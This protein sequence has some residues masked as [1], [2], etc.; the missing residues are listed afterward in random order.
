M[1]IV[2]ALIISPII[3]AI[4]TFL[5]IV[6]W[7]LWQDRLRL[8]INEVKLEQNYGYLALSA[9][10][11]NAGKR[12]AY[13]LR[14]SLS[15]YTQKLRDL[16]PILRLNIYWKQGKRRPGDW[17][18]I[19]VIGNYQQRIEWQLEH[20]SR[21][22]YP[23]QAQTSL[24]TNELPAG[25]K[26]GLVWP[27]DGSKSLP[28]F[29]VCEAYSLPLDAGKRFLVKLEVHATNAK[30][31]KNINYCIQELNARKKIEKMSY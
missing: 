18:K 31:R 4:I 5:L 6:G 7:S 1:D 16:Q 20:R 11:Y 3:T 29:E 14:S 25:A 28:Q 24:I 10:V 22:V 13:N 30:A 27:S 2:I 19:E 21:G 17:E 23:G 15:V 9:K 8:K 12:S 26:T